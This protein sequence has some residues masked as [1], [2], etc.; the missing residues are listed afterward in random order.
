VL[1]TITR[2]KLEVQTVGGKWYT[3]TIIP[4]RTTDNLIRGLVLT[5]VDITER[6]HLREKSDAAREYAEAILTTVREP[7]IVLDGELQIVSANAAFYRFFRTS[8]KETM[9]RY[10]YSLGNGQWDIARLRALLEEIIPKN[11]FFDE[12][13]VIG[14]FP[15]IGRRTMRLNARRIEKG[16]GRPAL[17]LPAFEDRAPRSRDARM[18]QQMRRLIV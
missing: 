2:K 8:E 18:M 6:H 14:D 16:C 9:G 15:Q 3:I 5:F 17:I 1:E 4:Y 12:Y 7:L 13:E 11:G 10:L